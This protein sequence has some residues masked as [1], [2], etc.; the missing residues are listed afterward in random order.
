MKNNNSTYMKIRTLAR[1]CI[2]NILGLTSKPANGIHILNGHHAGSQQ[3]PDIFRKLLKE[4][5]KDVS[6]I[7]IEDAIRMIEKKEKPDKPLVAFTFDDGFTDCYDIFAPVL[8]E[9]G[10]NAMF[11]VN[12]NY[13]EGDDNYISNFDEHIVMTPGKK[14]MRWNQLKELS[15]RGHIIGAHTMD[16]YMI[17]SEDLDVLKYQIENC[18]NIIEQHINISCPYFAFPYGKLTNA[19]QASIDIACQ[20]YQ[21][22]FSQSDYKN[23]FSFNGKVINRRHFEIFWPISHVHYFLSCKK[24]Y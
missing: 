20:K 4:L 7:K 14:P 6:F 18:R 3:D 13:V 2:L 5:S 10:V 24:R 12:P 8:E 15:Q 17:N 22:V 23:Y 1:Y 21:Y 19:N 9:F 11:F 16:H